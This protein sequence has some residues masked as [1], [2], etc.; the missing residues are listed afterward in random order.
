MH[1]QPVTPLHKVSD[2]CRFLNVSGRMLR[3]SCSQVGNPQLSIV[4]EPG[5]YALVL[6]GV[7]ADAE[8]EF[9]LDLTIE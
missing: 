3:L 1:P 9:T 4:L 5:A 7:D 8:G 2:L 6:E